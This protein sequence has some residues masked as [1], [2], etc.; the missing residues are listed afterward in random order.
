MLKALY[1]FKGKGPNELDLQVGDKMTL[2]KKYNDVWYW[3]EMN[4]KKGY[5][6]ASYVTVDDNPPLV[7]SA[8]GIL[9]R[10]ENSINTTV[11]ST[12]NK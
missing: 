7:R 10:E 9:A 4:G 1:P 12:R 6:P 8:S 3:V 11:Y 5:V 2:I